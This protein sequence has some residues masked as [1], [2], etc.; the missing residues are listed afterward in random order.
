[1]KKINK[2]TEKNTYQ[3][4]FELVCSSLELK[5][6]NVFDIDAL[7]ALF[8]NQIFSGAFNPT[9]DPLPFHRKSLGFSALLSNMSWWTDSCAE[10]PVVEC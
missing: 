3:N 8:G 9:V 7:F 4:S 2:K 5:I 10:K 6:K 1:M